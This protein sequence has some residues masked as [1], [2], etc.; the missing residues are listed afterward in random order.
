MKMHRVALRFM[1]LLIILFSLKGP[2]TSVQAYPTASKIPLSGKQIKESSPATA[3]F[4]G[5]GYKEIVVGGPDGILYVAAF[6]GSSWSVVW[7]RQTALEINA[8]NPDTTH[9]DNVIVSSPAI[10]DLDNDGHL[11]IVVTVGGPTHNPDLSARRNGGVL[12][13]RYNS[14]WD[15]SLTEQAT[16]NTSSGKCENGSGQWRG[17]PQPCIDQVGA[18][19]GEGLPDGLWDGIETTP[20]LGDL[21]GDGDLEIVINSLDRR[22]HA[23]H[24]TGEVVAGWPISQWDGDNLW[25]GGISSP[26]LGDI[27]NDGLPEV[28]VGTM[29]PYVNGQQDQNATLWA[30]N[31]DSSLVPGFPIQTEQHI[32]S[33]PALGD[34]DGD[35]YLEIVSGVGRG[36]TTGRQ[37]IVYAWN[38]DGTPLP[39]WPRE[40][41]NPMLAPPALGDIDG[42]GELEVVIGEGDIYITNDNKLYAWN[43][44]GSLVPG[45]PVTS[46]TPN[47]GTNSFPMMYSPVLV[48]FDGDGATEILITHVAAWG[49]VTIEPNGT[50][51]AVSHETVGALY[52]APL[53]DDVDNDG[54]LETIVAGEDFFNSNKGAIWIWDENGTTSSAQPWPMFHHDAQRTGLITPAPKLDFPDTT[55]LFH[56]QSDPSITQTGYVYLANAG[57]ETF[58]WT[59]SASVGISLNQL[60]GSGEGSVSFNVDLTGLPSGWS[61]MGTITASATFNGKPIMG[62]PQ[63]A[64][65]YVFIGDVAHVY[66]PIIRK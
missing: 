31:G 9:A 55:R 66:L 11:D 61:E 40:T 44:D 8:A 51:D 23:W 24:H 28:V 3:D 64:T 33:S 15:F 45:F 29:S 36:I 56:D 59:L 21:D 14:A 43:A 60:S 1:G 5:D 42:D 35:G 62:S 38:H 27:D 37:N 16:Y 34:I 58:D 65:V 19:A 63:T 50:S 26:A 53:V 13:Y 7:S 17:W 48:D 46:P 10:A 49:L 32:H 4:N 18:G 6:N 57:G 39:N 20:A 22:I 41:T 52:S 54:N 30:I 47:Y 2:S 25:R 12:I